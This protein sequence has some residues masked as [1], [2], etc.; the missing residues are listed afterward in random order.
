ML[1]MGDASS[2]P[3]FFVEYLAITKIG[4]LARGQLVLFA[5]VSIIDMPKCRLSRYRIQ[6]IRGE[7]AMTN[8]I[9]IQR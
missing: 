2:S 8:F 1:Q 9:H 7:V 4:L 5:I 3:V 6:M